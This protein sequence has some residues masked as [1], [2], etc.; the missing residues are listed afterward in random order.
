M[1]EPTEPRTGGQQPAV[2]RGGL[3][4]LFFSATGLLLP[5]FGA[6]LSIV[7]ISQG[8]RARRAA[9]ERDV[10]APGALMSMFLGWAG[11]AVSAFLLAGLAVFWNEYSTYQEC[12]TQAHTVSSQE[13]CDDTFREAVAERSGAPKDSIP[14]L[15]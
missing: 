14:S 5:P 11:I 4:G 13:A 6:L 10:A 12:T 3:W 2:E 1:T 9:R 15:N 8:R 7:G